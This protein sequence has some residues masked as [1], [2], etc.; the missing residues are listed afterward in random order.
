MKSILVLALF[1]L[2]GCS[3]FVS[4]EEL[5]SRALAT[6]DW[7][8]VEKR[9]RLITRRKMRSALAC[10]AGTTGYCESS[11]G[12]EEC[13]CIQTDALSAYLGR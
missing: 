9:E 2:A 6:G 4:L 5:E 8:E 7:S 12:R 10:P 13:S 11:F 1:F 3:S